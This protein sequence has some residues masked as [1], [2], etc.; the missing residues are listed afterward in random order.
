ML[1]DTV[2]FPAYTRQIMERAGLYDE[3]LVRNQDDE[4]NYRIRELGGKI[5]LADDVH[6]TYFSRA[7]LKDLWQQYL[8]Y[9]FWK[10]R[11]MQKHPHQMSLR[12]F[13][14]PAFVLVL[15]LGLLFSFF[16]IWV[17]FVLANVVGVYLLVNLG[18]SFW[19][20]S[21]RG[22]RSLPFLPLV[23]AILH[24]SYGLGF[25][26]GL[27]KFYDRWGDKVGRTPAWSGKAGE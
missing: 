9:G 23:F 22:W 15:L 14:P 26:M 1:I 6:S 19:T 8:E 4:Y 16:S 11:V 17:R 25:L 12:Q 18:V 21:K 24:F 27:G 20:A 7:S 2:P 13:V 10:V 3:E 5:L